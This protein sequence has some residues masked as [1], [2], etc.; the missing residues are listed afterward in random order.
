[1]TKKVR[2]FTVPSTGETI[3]I[4]PISRVATSLQVKRQNPEPQPP[5]LKVEIGG[6]VRYERNHADPDYAKHIQNWQNIVEMDVAERILRRVALKQ[7][8]TD[9]QRDEVSEFRAEVGQ[10]EELPENPKLT[11]LFEFA[12]G[13][14]SD[15][16]AII[17][18]CAS[19]A[20]PQEDG[21][22]K[23]ANNFRG[24]VSES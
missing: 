13:A 24:E 20:D 19:M 18:A 14:D 2:H 12:I 3:L 5:L 4:L 16:R 10:Y 17:E 11:W 15:V 7:K 9:E 23:E 21:I 6:Q 22:Q 1:M 8:L